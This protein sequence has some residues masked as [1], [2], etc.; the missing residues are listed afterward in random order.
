MSE[1]NFFQE[2]HKRSLA[3]FYQ[4]ET[5]MAPTRKTHRNVAFS[6]CPS[7]GQS[8]KTSDKFSIL[9]DT[10]FQCFGCEVHGDIID[11]GVLFW[12][13]SKIDAAK[14]I[15]GISTLPST[16]S[17]HFRST[18]EAEQQARTMRQVIQMIGQITIDHR[19]KIDTQPTLRYLTEQ[20][21]LSLSIVEEALRRQMLGFLPTDSKELTEL[22]TREIGR[23]LLE[24]SGLWK[25]Q[26]TMPGIINRPLVFFVPGMESAEFSLIQHSDTFTK[27]L[28]YGST[29]QVHYWKGTNPQSRQVAVAEGFL[30]LLSLA[31]LDPQHD[32]LGILGASNWTQDLFARHNAAHPGRTY[33]IWLDGDTA[34]KTNAQAMNSALE[35]LNLSCQIHNLPEG[36]D[37]NDVLREKRQNAA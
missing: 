17:A 23:P 1:I 14:R 31:D 25:P 16:S 15:A 18:E 33:H 8:A 32:I 28:R 21:G 22:L 13:C 29:K 7:C 10:T 11:L 5:G 36:K 26:K 12:G 34:G 37:V 24:A 30:D 19:N 6:F 4:S 27:R 9:S 3:Q 2:A 20:R 35:K